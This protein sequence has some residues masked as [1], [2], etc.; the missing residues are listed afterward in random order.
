[1][2]CQQLVGKQNPTLQ[3]EG[4]FRVMLNPMFSSC[5][6]LQMAGHWVIDAQLL[7]CCCSPEPCL[8][9]GA[10]SITLTKICF[11]IWGKFLGFL[12]TAYCSSRVKPNPGSCRGHAESS[13]SSSCCESSG[14]QGARG[15]TEPP[16]P[17]SQASRLGLSPLGL[18]S[19]S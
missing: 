13:S 9:E 18:P 7:S 3:K 12:L 11:Y 15:Q 1:M 4:G 19:L 5:A 17:P 6:A 10:P 2:H 16:S 8:N 14:A